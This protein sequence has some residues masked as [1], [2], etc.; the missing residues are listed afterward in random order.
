MSGYRN[1]IVSKGATN[2]SSGKLE[3]THE[4]GALDE[5]EAQLYDNI[6]L[7]A[8]DLRDL[9]GNPPGHGTALVGSL[10]RVQRSLV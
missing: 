10:G 4:S 2:Q 8:Q 6:V 7:T 3:A 1:T 5:I 9:A